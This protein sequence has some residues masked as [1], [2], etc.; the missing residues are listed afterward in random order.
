MI[1][2]LITSA[3]TEDT[4]KL[5]SK[6]PIKVDVEL[7]TRYFCFNIVK[8][9]Y[10]KRLH[11]GLS[12]CCV[13]KHANIVITTK[14]KPHRFTV[15][16]LQNISKKSINSDTFPGDVR[17]TTAMAIHK[18]DPG[19]DHKDPLRLPHALYERHGVS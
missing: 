15:V 2:T 1:L 10:F 5:V 17:Y 18:D 16:K 12:R 19:S 7:M 8:T 13:C 6:K 11:G 3:I 4:S 9:L 14:K